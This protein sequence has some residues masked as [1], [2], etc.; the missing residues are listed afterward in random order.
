VQYY[1]H[2]EA[3]LLLECKDSTLKEHRVRKRLKYKRVG[4]RGD[5]TYLYERT[6][7]EKHRKKLAKRRPLKPFKKKDRQGSARNPVTHKEVEA[8]KVELVESSEDSANLL[9]IEK[10]KLFERQT[11]NKIFFFSEE[12]Y[13]NP[14]YI[15]I[16][17]NEKQAQ[18]LEAWTNAEKK[19]F[20]FFG[21]NRLG[22]TAIASIIITSMMIGYFPWD[23][24]KKPIC[25]TP[26]KIR[27]VGQDWEKHIKT[28]IEPAL[29][30]WWPAQRPVYT[31]KNNFGIRHFWSDKLTNSSLEIMSNKSESAVFEGWNGDV[32][33]YDEPPKREVRTACA[34]GLVDFKGRELFTMTLLKEPWVYREVIQMKETDGRPDRSVFS[35]KGTTYDNVGYGIDIEGVE[36]FKKT[37][38]PDEITSRIEG[39]PSY[40]SGLVIPQ[41][42]REKH[43]KPRFKIPLDYIVDI[44]IDVHPKK[45][46]KVL[47]LATDPQ[48][49]K[50]ACY[51][52]SMHGDG[53]A[54]GEEI[55][56]VVTFNMFRVGSIIIDP[57]AKADSNNP[58][59]TYEKVNKVLFAF[60]YFL[61]T[62]DK[63]KDSGIL[64]IKN[65][66][67]GPNSEPSLWIFDD[68]RH[69]INEIEDWV[70][71]DMGKPS[72]KNDDMMENLYR[73]M[74]M[75]TQ[76][77]PPEDEDD[78]RDRESE[79]SNSY[80]NS[81]TG[82]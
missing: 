28:V 67:I 58:L 37:L 72:K 41:F 1:T 40:L 21:G 50:Y 2:E 52:I 68:M 65:S 24:D 77:Y 74:L 29:D 49:R 64:E 80:K 34:R 42:D 25:K 6:S 71:D 36:Q 46:Q 63:D 4:K 8:R 78:V 10:I 51:E 35:V 76:W 44:S 61:E 31:K 13:S 69:T 43:L 20:V 19:V 15:S 59:S 45:P 3:L 39:T 47:F 81:V 14:A 26:V 30:E 66:L 16:R 12:Y 53:K 55:I 17:P 33:V 70:Y 54:L 5:S 60:N 18:L 23:R 11:K 75:D 38:K 9:L 56:R 7:L 73:L 82:Y 27:W 62:A 32:V 48:N 57:L 79:R 22:K